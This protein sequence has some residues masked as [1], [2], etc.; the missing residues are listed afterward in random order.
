MPYPP[1]IPVEPTAETILR[2]VSR[3]FMVAAFLQGKLTP[4]EA[5]AL[6]DDYQYQQN[7]IRQHAETKAYQPVSTE[8]QPDKET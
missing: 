2:T 4:Q 1:A 6:W 5:V 7:I 3:A 8:F